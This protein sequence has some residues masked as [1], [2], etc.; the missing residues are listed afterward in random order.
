[1]ADTDSDFT[2]AEAVVV[3]EPA[4]DDSPG[5]ETRSRRL[6][7]E[8]SAQK[9]P[10]YTKKSAS[11]ARLP[12][13]IRSVTAMQTS[14]KKQLQGTDI[15]DSLALRVVGG[16][17]E[18]QKSFLKDYGKASAKKKS[19]IARPNVRGQICRLYRIS[20]KTYS[21]ILGDY[22]QNRT[23]YSSGKGGRGRA[24]NATTK[25]CRI[26]RTKAMQI[27]VREFV[28]AERSMK[29]RVT[30][31]QVLDFLIDR[32]AVVVERDDNGQFDKVAFQSAYRNV[33]RW[34]SSFGYQRGKRNNIVPNQANIAKR[35]YYLRQ[36]FDNRA[37]PK[38]TRL[39][40]VYTDESYIHEHY[41]R[42]TDSL[43]DPNDD[44]DLQFGKDK[45]KGRRYCFC[46][47]I[48]GPDPRV[49]M[50][51]IPGEMA[52]LV[53]GSVWAFCP[54]KKGDHH[55]DY[56]KVFNGTNYVQ[57]FRNQLLPNLHQPSMIMLD[58]AK[59]HS[60][61]GDD[62]PKVSGMR[63]AD[64]VAYLLFNGIN[65]EETMT[66]IELK[67]IVKRH[68]A[69]LPSEIEKLAEAA[70]HRVLWTPP[71]HSDLQPIELIWARVKGNVG[72]QYSIE[73]TLELVYT[74][75]I[76]E[77]AALDTANDAIN[78]M[79]EKC[80]QVAQKFFDEMPIDEEADEADDA[81]DNNPTTEAREAGDSDS[82]DTIV[83]E[84]FSV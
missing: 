25:E 38:E 64:C 55:G 49:D 21:K 37:A 41:H 5:I 61:K 62:V 7:R 12:N 14:I 73:S 72:R 43:W 9:K 15:D 68:V 83:G 31:R 23:I 17:L 71:Y 8:K 19:S 65:F 74:R 40:E 76:E 4:V 50:P 36:F 59:Y 16:A 29:R 84:T 18:L 24:G 11:R 60:V 58:N 57:W 66:S 44:Q 30:A 13:N 47:A 69:A 35:H 63:K 67:E 32:K 42:L 26:P 2:T 1:M 80:A 82:D 51:A 56:H 20:E 53:E 46:A 81:A 39:R 10:S 45:H 79:I 6:S 77:F 54:Q 52:N 27:R 3:D 75:L 28:R 78:G 70:G 33:R 34:L 48:Q 22:L